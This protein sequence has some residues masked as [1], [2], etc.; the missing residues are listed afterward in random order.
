MNSEKQ[1]GSLVRATLSFVVAQ[2]LLFRSELL[3]DFSLCTLPR[4]FASAVVFDIGCVSF[5]VDTVNHSVVRNV[6]RAVFGVSQDV[7]ADVVLLGSHV[8]SL[9]LGRHRGARDGV[10]F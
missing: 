10:C 9:L 3:A 4:V 6:G 8:I 7:T 2:S 5:V 1:K